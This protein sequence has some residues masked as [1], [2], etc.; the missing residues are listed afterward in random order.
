LLIRPELLPARSTEPCTL[1]TGRM[2]SFVPSSHN[3][4]GSDER[5]AVLDADGKFRAVLDLTDPGVPN[6]LDPVGNTRGKLQTRW[7]LGDSYPLPSIKKVKLSE[8]RE[9]LPADTPTVSPA[10]RARELEATR[11]ARC[12]ATA[13][14]RFTRACINSQIWPSPAPEPGFEITL[15]VGPFAITESNRRQQDPDSRPS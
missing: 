12:V 3:P 6:W 5:Q 9:H 13:T 15:A 4:G 10:E 8:L 14:N 11:A 1:W 7:Y 2:F